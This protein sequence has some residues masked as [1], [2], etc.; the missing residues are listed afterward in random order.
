MFRYWLDLVSN[1]VLKKT[2]IKI[3]QNYIRML[4]DISNKKYIGQAFISKYLTSK[5]HK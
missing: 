2:Q 4:F 1:R 5:L 3:L